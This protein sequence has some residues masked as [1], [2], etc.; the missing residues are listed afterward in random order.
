MKTKKQPVNYDGIEL[1]EHISKKITEAL[2]ASE[3]F[4]YVDDGVNYFTKEILLLAES[5]EPLAPGSE[6][7]IQLRK[8]IEGI[9]VKK[10]AKKV[11]KKI[12]TKLRM[13]S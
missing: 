7:A 9:D 5:I 4:D 10:S 11:K 2:E 1:D 13:A 12:D 3:S 8:A 6:C